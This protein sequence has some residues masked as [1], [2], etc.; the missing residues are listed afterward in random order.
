MSA[1]AETS[2]AASSAR[3]KR[4]RLAERLRRASEGGTPRPLSFSQQRLW[5]LDQL[6]TNSPLYN[7]PAVMRLTGKLDVAALDCALQAIVAR[8]EVL[9]SRFD[10]QSGIP[11]VTVTQEARFKLIEVTQGTFEAAELWCRE[12]VKRPFNLSGSEPLLRAALVRIAPNDHLLVLSM[13][14]IVSDEWSLKVL[15]RELQE[16]YTARLESRQAALPVLSIQYADYTVWQRRSLDDEM[17]RDQLAY[18]TEKL[19]DSPP[20]TELLTDHARGR[21]P[22]YNGRS[23]T[24]RIDPALK[25]LLDQLAANRQSTPFIVLLAAFMALVRHYT[26][27]DDITVGTPIAGRSRIETEELIG[28]FVNTLLLRADLS[29]NPTFDEI[30]QRVRGVALGAYA[31]QELPLEKLVEALKPERSL[32]HLVFTRIMFALQTRA[33]GDGLLELPGL[34]ADWID[35]DTGTAKFDL[36]FVVQETE[37]GLALRA[38]YNSDLFGEGTIR[39]LFGHYENLLRGIVENPTAHLSELPLLGA[40]ERQRLLVDWNRTTTD[41]PWQQCIPELFEAQARQRPDATAVV[42]GADSVTY[43]E[44][45][46]RANQ[47]AHYLRSQNLEPGAPVAICVERS[48]QMVVG[49]LGIL[50]AGGAYA[51]LDPSYPKERLAFMLDDTRTS[52][53]LTFQS[54]LRRFPHHGVKTVCF[55]ADGGLIASQS[56]ENPINRS[57]PDDVAYVIYTSGS[58]GQPKGV[59]VPHRAVNRLIVKTNYIQLDSTDRI[60]QVSNISFDAATFEIWGALLNGGQLHGITTDV[61]LA[62]KVFAGELREQGITAMFLT[63][64]LFSHLAAELPGTFSTL[65]TLIAGGE[66]LDPKAVRAVLKNN[67][68]LHLVNGYGPTENTTFTCC[69]LLQ[70]VPEK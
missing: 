4:A 48:V 11:R 54:F 13:H 5:F 67:P 17:M 69:A 7:V 62:P 3:E 41:Y 18:W 30:L 42:F 59:A 63:S 25:K 43:G 51:P 56:T 45:N 47:L 2:Q 44:L 58:T 37:S 20:V 39:R 28:F 22:T 16:F 24:Q 46:A 29:G 53:L 70:D 26:G 55:D 21:A 10:C 52:I 40:E 1:V 49:F 12:E 57:K 50:K 31:H 9:R 66:A 19:G 23:L 68:A 36:T 8:H 61:A 34:K 14:H 27:I 38:E 6:E 65:R 15:F 32:N 64:A 33:A 60:A 35:I